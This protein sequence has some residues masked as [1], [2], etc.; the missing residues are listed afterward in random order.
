MIANLCVFLV[1]ATLLLFVHTV[2]CVTAKRVTKRP[3]YMNTKPRQSSSTVKTSSPVT[4]STVTETIVNRAIESVY[5]D[6]NI[7]VFHKASG[8]AIDT[9]TTTA[10]RRTSAIPLNEYIEAIIK[11]KYGYYYGTCKTNLR[12]WHSGIVVYPLKSKSSSAIHPQST[13]KYTYVVIINGV[14]DHKS[15]QYGNGLCTVTTI[16]SCTASTGVLSMLKME[17]DNDNVNVH[18][19]KL[20]I[21][22]NCV[23]LVGIEI[24]PPIVT[25]D[26]ITHN[27]QTVRKTE[28]DAMLSDS[29]LIPAG[30]TAGG[31]AIDSAMSIYKVSS[32]IPNKFLKLIKRG[33]LFT[34][35]LSAV[36]AAATGST[37]D[38]DHTYNTIRYR[39]IDL[40][41]PVN[42]LVPRNSSEV[43]IDYAI[44][45]MSNSVGSDSSDV[46]TNIL[47]IGCG[48]ASLLL[49][50]LHGL[51]QQHSS[52]RKYAGYGV[53]I[54][55]Y[56]L[57]LA[58]ENAHNNKIKSATNFIVQDFKCLHNTTS[59]STAGASLPMIHYDCILCN[60]PYLSKKTMSGRVT[61]ESNRVLQDD[62]TSSRHMYGVYDELLSSLTKYIEMCK[63][64]SK[65]EQSSILILQ[66]PG[67]SNA[68]KYIQQV[69]HKY[70]LQIVDTLV[71]NRRNNI[72][73]I[74]RAIVV[75]LL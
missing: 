5:D 4:T 39:S 44:K 34:E 26:T 69:V 56:S 13:F 52:N 18:I 17:F 32:D 68:L 43:L 65:S 67:N 3:S 33:K 27:I 45:L 60:P 10:E 73:N 59:T 24:Y 72:D 50:T 25:K 21:A 57:E 46:V 7:I 64:V 38:T 22:D 74:N 19:D 61:T 70:N 20:S 23:S 29:Q 11:E 15:T 53:D 62:S 71:I 55:E 54:D 35:R 12:S 2:T 14:F 48:S 40:K 51:E 16:D 66:L 9:V 1:I 37:K 30:G 42:S 75:K 47:D 58:K 49:S 8:V 31:A 6:T 36:E 41:Y 28:I 63:T